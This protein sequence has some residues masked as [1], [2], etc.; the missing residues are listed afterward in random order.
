MQKT[1]KMT[2]KGKKLQGNWQVD[3]IFMNLKKKL[4][5]GSILTLSWGYIHVYMFIVKQ[6]C[7]YI[8]Q[9]SGE[10]LQSHWSS[11]WFSHD[12]TEIRFKKKNQFYV[13]FK[14]ISAHETGQ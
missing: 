5:P 2:L 14:I 3:R 7:W 12:T 1:V 10:R 4:T 11:G 6:V 13:T 9:I 8:S